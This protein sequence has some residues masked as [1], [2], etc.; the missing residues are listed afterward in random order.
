MLPKLA[1]LGDA[2]VDLS[3]A[4]LWDALR[5]PPSTL[6]RGELPDLTEDMLATGDEDLLLASVEEF[7]PLLPKNESSP[8][9]GFFFPSSATTGSSFVVS[10]IFHP[11]GTISSCIILGLDF[12]EFSQDVEPFD[13]MYSAIGLDRVTCECR[14]SLRAS[15][16]CFE[17]NVLENATF[18]GRTKSSGTNLSLIEFL[19][20]TTIQKVQVVQYMNDAQSKAINVDST[21]WALLTLFRCT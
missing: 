9:L 17:T 1:T 11:A 16:I 3:P 13:A 2:G 5:R 19:H 21:L 6:A 14:V 12:K 15:D 18:T 7:V 4:T 20:D 10:R 8:P